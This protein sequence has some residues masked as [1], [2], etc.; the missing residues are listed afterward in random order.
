MINRKSKPLVLIGILFVLVGI[1]GSVLS[2]AELV[3][4][5]F[6]SFE[7]WEQNQGET[8]FI[9]LSVPLNLESEYAQEGLPPLPTLPALPEITPGSSSG[10][11]PNSPTP[12]PVFTITPQAT[13]PAV[14][15]TRL[16]IPSI[17]LDA[18]VLPT[19]AKQTRI[20]R[21]VYEQWQAPNKFAAGWYTGSA[22]LGQAGNT[23]LVGHHNVDGKVFENLHKLQPG[24]EIV[25]IG[26]MVG[27]RYQVVNVMILPERNV[28]VQ[29]RL[30]NARWILPSEDERI[31]LV[32]CWPA[33]T[34]THRLIVVAQ[35]VGEPLTISEEPAA[36]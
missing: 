9:P 31:T 24:D 7:D 16:I 13:R 22:V 27:Y 6:A 34:N 19:K 36:Y 29:T 26:G 3:G 20:G 8:G 5:Q 25:L 14:I 28:D 2:V 10:N 18:P 23:V 30:E 33:W 12:I 21:E 17:Q 11:E 15:P 1:T 35:P 32:T 4:V